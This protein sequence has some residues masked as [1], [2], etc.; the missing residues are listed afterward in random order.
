[1]LP[2]TSTLDPVNV[3]PVRCTARDSVWLKKAPQRG[4]GGA[5]TT[6]ET[7]KSHSTQEEET[8]QR[9]GISGKWEVSYLSIREQM[10]RKI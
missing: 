4:R 6:N 5:V 8:G 3:G 1:M 2:L 10:S 9:G 7:K